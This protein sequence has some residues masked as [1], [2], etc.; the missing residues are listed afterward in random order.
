MNQEIHWG[1]IVALVVAIVGIAA[2]FFV[3]GKKSSDRS[4]AINQ[5]SLNDKS[6]I[7]DTDMSLRK[8]TGA[9]KTA[10]RENTKYRNDKYGFEFSYPSYLT[11]SLVNDVDYDA[12]EPNVVPGL[13]ISFT[14][15][16]PALADVSLSLSVDPPKS[17]YPDFSETCPATD[18]CMITFGETIDGIKTRIYTFREGPTKESLYSSHSI[19]FSRGTKLVNI[20][21]TLNHV[22]SFGDKFPNAKEVDNDADKIASSFRFLK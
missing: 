17:W 1:K 22:V 21:S 6:K 13:K 14:N 12:Q 11:V 20:H 4:G 16:D 7:A 10:H 9:E 3:V 8:D 2:V 19:R 15:P 18:D 5:Q